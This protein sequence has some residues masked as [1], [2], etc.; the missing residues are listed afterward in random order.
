M[1][2][3]RSTTL[4]RPSQRLHYSEKMYSK[5]RHDYLHFHIIDGAISSHQGIKNLKDEG[6]ITETEYTTLLEKNIE[7]LID[8]IKEFRIIE[9]MVCIFFAMLFG[10]M[11]VMADDLEMVRAGRTARG[12]RAR[13]GRTGRRNGEGDE[14]PIYV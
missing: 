1:K 6:I 2:T 14:L 9:R 7:R 10:Y 12:A 13:T 3:S 8:R 11:Q 4:E 5:E